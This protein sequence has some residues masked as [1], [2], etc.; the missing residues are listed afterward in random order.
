MQRAIGMSADSLYKTFLWGAAIKLACV[1]AY[2]TNA[3]NEQRR[4]KSGSCELARLGSDKVTE[5][6]GLR[7]EII[8]HKARKEAAMIYQKVSADMKLEEMTHTVIEMIEEMIHTVREHI[9][10][11]KELITY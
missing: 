10:R 4:T 3:R 6:L 9:I 11:M 1:A 2:M 7:K 8:S 5:R